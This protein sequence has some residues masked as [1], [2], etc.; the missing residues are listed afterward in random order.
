MGCYYC[1]PYLKSGKSLFLFLSE[2]F[3]TILFL[4]AEFSLRIIFFPRKAREV[5]D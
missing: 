2:I 3:F 1:F 4:I 5:S